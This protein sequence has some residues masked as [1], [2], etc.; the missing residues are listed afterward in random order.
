MRIARFWVKDEGEAPDP[1]GRPWHLGVHGWSDTSVADAARVARERL[2]AALA[3]VR[4]GRPLLGG[5]Y[6]R[7]PLREE[8]LRELVVDGE[9]VALVT[10]NRDAAHVLNT[11]RVLVADIDAEPPAAPARRG[12]WSR[13]LGRAEAPSADPADDPRTH[14][15]VRVQAWATA[16]P[17]LGVRAY[18]T[19]G[20][21][22]L[23]TGTDAAPASQEARDVLVGLDSD[24]V[25][26]EL[27]RQH[28][29]YRAR[30][31]AKPWRAGLGSIRINW[32]FD[33]G[34]DDRA[35][36]R[37]DEGV[38]AYAA[39]DLLST[40]GPVPDPGSAEARIIALHDELSGVGTGRP[41][42]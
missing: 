15:L 38:A 26:I 8:T 31:T 34:A 29:T 40:H 32:P 23:V 16:H 39:A 19:A 7:L 6:P 13:L 37:Y 1:A 9:T 30:L 2:D 10:R 14:A 4:A 24:P 17:D 41:L 12:R 21:R 27:C 25:Y 35:I 33:G 11:E 36:Q 20:L 28:E 5:Y 42:A 3:E 22:V 18:V